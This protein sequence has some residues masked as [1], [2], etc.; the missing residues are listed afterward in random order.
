MYY[1]SVFDHFNPLQHTITHC[2]PLQCTRSVEHQIWLHHCNTFKHSATLWISLHGTYSVAHQIWP[3]YCNTLKHTATLWNSLHG[4]YSVAHQSVAHIGSGHSPRPGTFHFY[5]PKKKTLHFR[6]RSSFSP[7]RRLR[8][9]WLNDDC[10]LNDETL[11]FRQ[12]SMYFQIFPQ[13]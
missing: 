9:L 10:G 4:T 7:K 3:H 5:T 1:Q 2:D 11:H 13:P 8:R 6:Q 12:R